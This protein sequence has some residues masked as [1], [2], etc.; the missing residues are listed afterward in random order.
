MAYLQYAEGEPA[1][2]QAGAPAPAPLAHGIPTT[3]GNPPAL[4]AEM[5]NNMAKMPTTLST[6]GQNPSLT[7]SD[8][9]YATEVGDIA[10]KF[11]LLL[12][13]TE[14]VTDAITGIVTKEVILPELS[15]VLI[16]VYNLYAVALV[17]CE[18]RVPRATSVFRLADGGVLKLEEGCFDVSQHGDINVPLVV[19][20]PFDGQTTIKRACP[21]SGDSG[22]LVEGVEKVIGVLFAHVLDS[23]IVDDKGECNV[24]SFVSPQTW[25]AWSGVV[26]ELGKVLGET[27]ACN[28]AGLFES[29]HALSDFHVDPAVSIGECQ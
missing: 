17:C 11:R 25:S 4:L 29:V 14:F 22:E 5:T 7:K 8:R 24:A 9:D 19:I 27:L 13:R 21:I 16:T 18:A 10:I 26:S 1:P 2:V 3:G 6:M 28:D 15:D 23:E 20:V 12:S